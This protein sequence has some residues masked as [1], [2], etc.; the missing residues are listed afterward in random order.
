MLFSAIDQQESA[1]GIH[2]FSPSWTSLPSPPIPLF[3]VVTEHRKQLPI[4]YIM[5][6]PGRSDGKESARNAGDPGS[7]PESGRS[8]GEGNGQPLQ[9]SCLGNPW[10][11]EPGGPQSTALHM[12]MYVFQCYSPSSSP[13]SFLCCVHKSILC[14]S[15]PAVQTGSSVPF[16]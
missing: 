10:T 8:L 12:V 9:Y 14:V 5:G 3:Q 15:I 1:I 16:F 2:N 13:H 7:S 6:L 4:S 11:E